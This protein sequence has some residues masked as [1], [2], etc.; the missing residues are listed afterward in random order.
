MARILNCLKL[1]LLLAAFFI[2]SKGVVYAD[3]HEAT[4]DAKKTYEVAPVQ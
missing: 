3:D 4:D 1:L 2:V